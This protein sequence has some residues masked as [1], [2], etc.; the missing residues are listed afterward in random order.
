MLL[1]KQSRRAEGLMRSV[2]QRLNIPLKDLYEKAWVPLEETFGTAYEGLER[3]AR[4]GVDVLLDIGLPRDLAEA[5][6][7]VAKEKIKV[8][9]VKVKG[10]LNVSCVKPDGVLRIKK[11]L[12]EAKS[13]K[14]PRGS[15]VR[16]YVISPPKYRVEVTARDYKTAN[17]IM[18][19]VAETAVNE[20]KRLGGDGR[21]ERG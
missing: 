9:S 15:S 10:I 2:S 1:W 18:Q 6:T 8:A 11:A 13:V 3:A 16:I 14:A 12:M 21:F 4:D 17:Q 20:I 19:R 7:E 5:L